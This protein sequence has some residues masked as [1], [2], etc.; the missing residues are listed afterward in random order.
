MSPAGS[1]WKG[2]ES[3][4]LTAARPACLSTSGEFCS[5]LG[6]VLSRGVPA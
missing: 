6:G 2:V 5:V 3:A 1:Q 4:W